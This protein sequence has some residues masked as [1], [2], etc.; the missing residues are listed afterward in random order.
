[1]LEVYIFEFDVFMWIEIQVAKMSR[2]SAQ[3]YTSLDNNTL[4]IGSMLR[5]YKSIVMDVPYIK[6]GIQFAL[7]KS[8]MLSRV[9]CMCMWLTMASYMGW[10]G[11]VSLK[12]LQ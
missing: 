8:Y 7:H 12:N 2:T 10:I 6:F 5:A 1:V 11:H 3:I 9:L 4:S